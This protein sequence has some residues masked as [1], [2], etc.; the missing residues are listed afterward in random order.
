MCI[1]DSQGI[2]DRNAIIRAAKSRLGERY[3]IVF[4]NCEH[5]VSWVVN[6]KPESLQVKYWVAT[7]FAGAAIGLTAAAL[8]SQK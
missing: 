3:D 7:I 5:F 8:V 2:V 6:G 4:S 1:R